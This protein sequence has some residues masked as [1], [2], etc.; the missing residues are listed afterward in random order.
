LSTAA[1]V[2]DA[3][4]RLRGVSRSFSLNGQ[5]VHALDDVT[6]DVGD[7]EFVALVGP[8][9][10]GK[11]T[12]LRI[13]AGLLE[14]SDGDVTV[15]GGPPRAAIERR[16]VGFVFQNPV[17]MPWRS[18]DANVRLPLEV[19]GTLGSD[20]RRR[21]KELIHLVGLDG[22]EGARP[23]QLSGG[24]RQ[25]A[26]LARALITRPRLLLLDE[27][28]GA[29]DEITRQR[30]NLELLRIWREVGVTSVLV[31]HSVSEAV[32]LA[33]RVVVLTPRPGRIAQIVEVGLEGYARGVELLR[34][35]AFFERC[36]AV[37]DALYSSHAV[38]VA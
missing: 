28:F 5:P 11:S 10:C 32:F 2:R 34:E 7:G 33:H 38:G 18:V 31:T 4:V 29:L 3:A 21:V 37:S 8:S 1:E 26:A 16:S 20:E 9:G 15:F 27:P 24:M 25:R 6:L 13:M 14:P 30:M 12:L 17:L 35:P 19:A 23:S 36:A 22:F